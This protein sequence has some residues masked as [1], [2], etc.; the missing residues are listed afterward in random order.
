MAP[1]TRS[2]L[3]LDERADRPDRDKSRQVPLPDN[4]TREPGEVEA[5][6]RLA[7]EIHARLADLSIDDHPPS[8]QV[9]GASVNL[10]FPNRN[11]ERLLQPEREV[12]EVDGLGAEVIDQR[13]V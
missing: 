13:H 7:H 1:V 2:E 4:A 12:D 8:S 10:V 11:P 6:H 3:A 5:G 9:E